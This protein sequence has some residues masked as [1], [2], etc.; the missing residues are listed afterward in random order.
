[1]KTKEW[2]RNLIFKSSGPN[3]NSLPR[4]YKDNEEKPKMYSKGNRLKQLCDTEN[5]EKTVKLLCIVKVL[6]IFVVTDN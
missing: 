6:K 2:N 4:T 5:Q 1:M 3:R